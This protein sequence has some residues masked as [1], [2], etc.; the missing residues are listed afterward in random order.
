MM[1]SILR[2]LRLVSDIKIDQEPEEQTYQEIKSAAIFKGTNLWIM[3]F[4]MIISCVGLN[5][6]SKA[7]VIGAMII[8]PLM[9]PVFGIGFALGT[10]DKALLQLSAQNLIR[11]VM[12]C[13]ACSSLYY[14]LNPYHLPTPELLSFSR[15][16]I[17]D[18]VL[19]FLGGLAG[20]IAITRSEGGR[21]LVGVAVATACIPPLC[22]AGFGLATSQWSYFFGGLYTFGIN[23]VFICYATFIM[24]RYLKFT[25]KQAQTNKSIQL[26]FMLLSLVMIL[27]AS[28][29]AYKMVQED[30]YKSKVNYFI[31][32]EVANKYHILQKEIDLEKKLIRVD[33]SHGMFIDNLQK[34][35]EKKLAAYK[36]K[37]SH[38]E[39]HQSIDNE[40]AVLNL[41]QELLAMKQQIKDLQSKK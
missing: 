9:G 14:Y 32:K 30:L 4:A 12:I 21:V 24:T 11:I 25:Q 3:A 35:L 23:A 2:Y 39:I 37:D 18:I 33:L 16:T 1:N 20:M 38:V 29:F 41:E 5:I 28:Y 22:T 31:E 19:A 6:N 36:I 40:K 10:A 7:A 15:P 8:S 17:F 27:P 26:G 13:I 34:D